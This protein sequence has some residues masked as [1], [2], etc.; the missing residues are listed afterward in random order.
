VY[1]LAGE[2]ISNIPFQPTPRPCDSG[3]SARRTDQVEER[4]LGQFELS[5]SPSYVESTGERASERGKF[6]P[7]QLSAYRAK[8]DFTV[9][10]AHNDA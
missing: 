4:K 10:L 8:L 3:P 5:I 7:L 2:S 1:A 6:S 9:C